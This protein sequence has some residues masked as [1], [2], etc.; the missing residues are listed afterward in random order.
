MKVGI[1]ASNIRAG[2]GVTHLSQLLAHA[3]PAAAGIERVV[4]WAPKST[5]ARIPDRPWLERRSPEAL[6]RSLP[7][8]ILWQQHTLPRELKREGCDWL[9]SPGSTLPARVP[10]SVRTLTLSQNMLPFQPEESIRF[11]FGSL[12]WLKMKL[13]RRSQGRSFRQAD[14]LLFLTRFARDTICR[15]LSIDPANSAIVPHGIEP[16][17][18]I[19][20]TAGAQ[21][22]PRSARPFRLLYVSII[23]VYK[24]QWH[25]AEAV[26]SLRKQGLNV[27]IDFVGPAYPPALARLQAA[28][29]RL[30]PARQA[31]R[32]RGP[33]PFEQLHAAY[34]D[35]DAFVFAS[36]CENLP[37]ILLEAMAAGLPIACSDRG[38][39]PE[40]LGDSGFYFDPEKPESI[41]VA[42]RR[43]VQDPEAADRMRRE[44]QDKAREYTWESCARRTFEAIRQEV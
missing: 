28:L 26:A 7:W 10:A 30:D 3:D 24:H 14:R 39:M 17:F 36:S 27:E 44:C 11:G 40:V 13:L 34:R 23:D 22:A 41:A 9:F 42:I 25:V 6:E 29:D 1:D 43:L 33:M 35:A 18:F 32:Y 12:M 5:H 15:T 8:R 31:L 37:N 16:R 38:P 4:L 19:D 2:G 20:R 21:A